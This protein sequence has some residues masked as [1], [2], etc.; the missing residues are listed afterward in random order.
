MYRKL[1]CLTA[2]ALSL[3]SARTGKAEIVFSDAFN[4]TLGNLAGQNG[5]SGFST[6]YTGGTS[7]VS[8]ALPG[9]TGNSVAIGNTGTFRDLSATR[10]TAGNTFYFSIISRVNSGFASYAGIS[11]F[12]TGAERLFQ[13][14]PN[15]PPNGQLGVDNN[16]GTVSRWSGTQT[17]TTYLTLFALTSSGGNTTINMYADTNLALTGNDLIATGSKASVTRSDF[18]FNRIRIEGGATGVS[19][20][21]MAMATTANEAVGFT[22]Q[23]VPEPGT[24]L[25]G[26]IAAACGGGGVWWK[27]RR[28]PVENQLTA[29]TPAD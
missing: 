8:G 3:L 7:Q 13:G 15:G 27:R 1:F 12:E 22:T 6:A 5:G 11:L 23:S 29:E 19:F 26:G 14:V 4:Y 9:T 10:S 20:A 25:L 2:L 17:D 16:A 24:L 28:R 18:S 21:G